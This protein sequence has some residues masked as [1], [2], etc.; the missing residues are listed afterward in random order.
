VN[1]E[2]RLMFQLFFRQAGSHYN[3]CTKATRE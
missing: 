3:L 2:S 1:V